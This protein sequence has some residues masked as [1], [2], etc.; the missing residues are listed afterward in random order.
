[1]KNIIT[2]MKKLGWKLG[3]MKAIGYE[4]EFTCA[5]RERKSGQEL[6]ND[7]QGVFYAYEDL[8]DYWYADPLIYQYEDKEYVFMEA[9]ER[10]TG[11]GRIAIAKVGKEGWGRPQV[12]IEEDFH[13]S[14]PMI[15]EYKNTLYM[16][17]ETSTAHKV[18]LYR[19]SEFPLKW[20]K[21]AELLHGRKLVDIVP[22]KFEEN[23]VT[24]LGSE[25]EEG[26]LRVRFQAFTVCFN[27]E[28]SVTE[29]KDYNTSQNY[30][31]VNRNGGIRINNHL[32][33]QKSTPAIYGY[34]ILFGKPDKILPKDV[35]IVKEVK[36]ADIKLHNDKIR[37]II[38]THTYSCTKNYELIDVQY[39]RFNKMKWINR[40]RERRKHEKTTI[41]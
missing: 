14:F 3:I 20:E 1:M 38:G 10:E 40:Y 34:S 2:K 17:P 31:Y 12:I 16:I 32:I 15:F 24:F 13:L 36:P 18:I 26:S 33:L 35:N 30:N 22:V 19:C 39:M 9:Y 7:G 41:D 23:E 4:A 11:L 5:F 25:C 29:W 27:S 28:Y 21:E 37:H 8:E 6:I